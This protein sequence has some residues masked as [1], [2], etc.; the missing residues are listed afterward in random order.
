MARG[1]ERDRTRREGRRGW[2][3]QQ[4]WPGL[5]E[6][7][8]GASLAA[9]TRIS[10]ALNPSYARWHVEEVHRHWGGGLCRSGG[11]G[12]G[13]TRRCE[14]AMTE[15]PEQMHARLCGVIGQAQFSVLGE[16]YARRPIAHT[17]ALSDNAL[18]AV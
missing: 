8:S 12:E 2:V 17:S 13:A 14:N 1:D 11:G 18:A 3:A 4:A 7:K 6:T 10:L 5:S 16:A 9:R 15:T